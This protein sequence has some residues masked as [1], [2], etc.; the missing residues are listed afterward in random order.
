MKCSEVGST[1]LKESFSKNKTYN[2]RNVVRNL[3]RKEGFA[4]FCAVVGKI[5]HIHV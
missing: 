3:T 2:F 1:K 5:L 4:C